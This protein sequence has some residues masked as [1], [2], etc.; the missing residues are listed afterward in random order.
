VFAIADV[1]D[2]LT[3]DRPYRPASSIAEAREIINRGSGTHFD[4]KV[5]QAFNGI[6]DETFA[7]IVADIR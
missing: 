2:A 3:T 5:V 4:P 7:S 6:E 1:L